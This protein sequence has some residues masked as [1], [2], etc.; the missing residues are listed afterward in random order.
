MF[1]DIHNTTFSEYKTRKKIKEK[2]KSISYYKN[3]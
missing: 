3:H 1:P 2:E